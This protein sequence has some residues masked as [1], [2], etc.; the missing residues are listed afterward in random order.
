MNARTV[1][2]LI[3][4]VATQDGA[5]V[6]LQRVLGARP[7]SRL[8]PLLMLDAFSSDDPDDYIAGFPAHPHRGFETVTYILDG[9]MLHEDH[10][11]HRGDL[12]AGGVQWM[13]AGRGIIHSEMPQQTAGRLRGFQLWLNLPAREKMKPASY[14]DI[15]AEDIP[16]LRHA[17]GAAIKVIAGA[18]TLG[19][20][21]V[22][23][24]IH[25]GSTAPLYY[26]VTLAP[27]AELELPLPAGHNCLL[28]VFEG[29]LALGETAVPQATA[30]ILSDGDYL[31]LSGRAD[32]GRCL[33]VGG[34][35]LREPVVQYGPFV[36]NSPQEIQQAF[37]D[38]RRTA[39][40]GWPWKSDDPVH[41]REEGRFARHADGRVEKI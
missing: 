34:K 30:A 1:S 36:M 20:A 26:D 22:T 14:R 21:T 15:P 2:R 38:Y 40:G 41:P 13:T 39:F 29:S 24:P 5:G 33:V 7:E 11:G 4:A 32:G 16:L 6:R 25:G 35:P 17:G 27:G 8:D 28:Y 19:G 12:T 37:A 9:H 10:L 31:P 3:P 23:G 18:L